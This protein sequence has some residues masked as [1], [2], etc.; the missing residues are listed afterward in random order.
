LEERVSGS[1][2]AQNIWSP[3][4]I[5]ALILRDRPTERYWVQQDANWN[6]TAIV[7]TA[8]AVV[9]RY[10]YY[11]YGGVALYDPS[12][13]IESSNTHDWKYLFQGGRYDWINAYSFR[14]RNLNASLDRWT[15]NDPIGFVAGDTNTYRAETNAPVNA[16]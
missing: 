15:Q 9:E 3:V 16:T 12:W 4:Y 6:V 5:D 1:M 8:G 13:T 11:P 10:V 7:S 14:N 2:T